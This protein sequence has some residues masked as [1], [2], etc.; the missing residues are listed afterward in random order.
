VLDGVVG[1]PLASVFGAAATGGMTTVF[2]FRLSSGATM[3]AV[4]HVLSSPCTSD[5][6]VGALEEPFPLAILHIPAECVAKY[7]T[8]LHPSAEAF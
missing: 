6:S 2:V 1:V 3:M 8:H 4:G 5:G 7:A